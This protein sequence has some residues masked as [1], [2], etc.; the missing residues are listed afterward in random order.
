MNF[1]RSFFAIKDSVND[2]VSVFI[3]IVGIIA[4]VATISV[5]IP[6][7]IYLLKRKKTGKVKF[8]SF[9]IFFVALCSWIIFG[10]FTGKDAKMA[11][12]VYA[13]IFCA[14]VYCV[15]LFF[16]YK[17]DEKI[18]RNKR[19]WIVLSITL[20]LTTICLVVGLI[21]LYFKK[22]DGST[23]NFDDNTTAILSQIV[24]VMTTFAFLPQILKTFEKRDI[25]GLSIGLILMFVLTNIF[26]IVYWFSL[27]IAEGRLTPALTS[28]LLWQVLSLLIYTSQLSMMINIIKSHKKNMENQTNQDQNN[29]TIVD[30]NNYKTGVN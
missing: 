6:Q 5:S 8:Y 1:L 29:M 4:C 27:I 19:K 9:W 13:N 18:I 23:L 25:E 16:M 15:L 26:W 12:V 14:Y 30:Q 7:L 22:K 24:P 2:G 28:T 21:G 11:A 3:A 17:Y 20:S 10:S